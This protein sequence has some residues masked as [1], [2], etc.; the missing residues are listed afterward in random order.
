MAN[1]GFQGKNPSATRPTRNEME[2]VERSR[3]A[4]QEQVKQAK[5]LDWGDPTPPEPPADDPFASWDPI[6]ALGAE[7]IETKPVKRTDQ[8]GNAG[9]PC[10][11]KQQK[12]IR[13]IFAEKHPDGDL[14]AYITEVLGDQFAHLSELDK[15]QASMVIDRLKR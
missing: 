10:T 9:A 8:L 5:P 4:E 2:K 12:M 11:D 1:F 6:A 15:W 3:R 14:A 7:I 13:A